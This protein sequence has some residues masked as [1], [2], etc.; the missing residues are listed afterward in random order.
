M[1]VHVRARA[2]RPRPPTAA[3]RPPSRRSSARA[4]AVPGFPS[5]NSERSWSVR[6]SH[7]PAFPETHAPTHRDRCLPALRAA[8]HRAASRRLRA[9][10]WAKPIHC[11]CAAAPPQSAAA[12]SAAAQY[13]PLP[14][15]APAP[16]LKPYRMSNPLDSTFISQEV[17]KIDGGIF[18]FIGARTRNLL[19]FAQQRLTGLDPRALA[20]TVTKLKTVRRQ[21]DDGR[22]MLEPSHLIALVHA[23]VAGK[24][25]RPARLRIQRAVDAMQA[26]ACHQNGGDRHNRQRLARSETRLDHRAFVLAEETLDP[27]QRDRVDV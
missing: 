22:A 1:P 25:R 12:S 20:H 3:S 26:E 2:A 18:L 8:P 27:L 14:K 24:H 6:P 17:C 7:R 23:D 4:S 9:C 10:L 21:H 5:A 15:Q 11:P 13:L 19:R 16:S